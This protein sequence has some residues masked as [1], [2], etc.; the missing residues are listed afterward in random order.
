MTQL[1]P[2]Q[3]NFRKFWFDHWKQAKKEPGIAEALSGISTHYMEIAEEKFEGSREHDEEQAKMEYTL[4]QITSIVK[5]N[6]LY[7][8]RETFEGCSLFN[9]SL[10]IAEY[11]YPTKT[12]DVIENDELAVVTDSERSLVFDIKNGERLSAGASLLTVKD[13]VFIPTAEDVRESNAFRAEKCALEEAR[14]A[15][16]RALLKRFDNEGSVIPL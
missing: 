6:D 11:L 5:V 8:L 16:M 2:T 3:F 9:L 4:D 7:W 12:W 13:E 10:A 14:L 1:P 15:D